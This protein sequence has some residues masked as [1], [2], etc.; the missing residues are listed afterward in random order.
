[1]RDAYENPTYAFQ[2]IGETSSFSV[3][4][5]LE[6]IKEE[7]NPFNFLLAPHAIDLPLQYTQSE[8]A[9]LLAYFA[10]G[11]KNDN[12]LEKAVRQFA[13]TARETVPYLIELIQNLHTGIAYEPRDEPGIFT[14]DEM[15]RRGKGSCRDYAALLQKILQ[16]EGFATRFVSG[17]LLDTGD[18]L[19]AEAMH[20]WTDVFLPGAGWIGLDPTNGVLT[21]SSF[22]PCAVSTLPDETTPVYGRY[23][24]DSPVESALSMNLQITRGTGSG[25][26]G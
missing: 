25:E 3:T 7:S 4:N 18:M 12:V 8:R 2:F 23:Y 16:F 9:G 17:Y 19:G 10:S 6:V 1:M 13:P 15:L 21:D 14:V 24:S 11:E 22:I 26:R 5:H 20:A